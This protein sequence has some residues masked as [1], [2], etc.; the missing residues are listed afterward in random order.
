[1]GAFGA[2]LDWHKERMSF[3]DNSKTIPAVH[4]V[5]S[6]HDAHAETVR[7]P[8]QCSVV[9]ATADVARQVALSQKCQIK[10]QHEICVQVRSDAAPKHSTTA[11]IE[12]RFVT[13]ELGTLSRSAADVWE[14]LIVARSVCTWSHEDGSVWIQLANPSDETIA[15][16]AGTVVGHITPVT[17][18]STVTT[19]AIN[20]DC[21]S[22]DQARDELRPRLASAFKGT[23]FSQIQCHEILDLCAKYRSVFS[24]TPQELGTCTLASADFPLQPGTKPVDRPP[25]KSNP[26]T[27]AVIADCVAKMEK[28][29][30]I[31][32]RASPWGSPVCIIVKRD[33]SPRFCVDYRSTINKHLV[34]RTW[35]MPDMTSCIDTAGGANYMSVFDIQSAFWQIPVQKDHVD[36]TAFVTEHGKYVFKRMPFGIANAPWMFQR[37]MALTFAHFGPRSGLLVY[38]DDL[39]VCSAT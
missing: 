23:V 39:I 4:R 15:V 16:R 18:A 30:I 28:D 37:I 2:V 19:S 38:M 10:P 8:S 36:R 1:M 12:P 33:G 34:R 6:S 11:V 20:T 35:P 25:Y 32:Q 22:V 17:V 24:L 7:S 21:T 27:Q 13:G 26:R 3:R 31:E 14:C 5:V 29:G 9:V